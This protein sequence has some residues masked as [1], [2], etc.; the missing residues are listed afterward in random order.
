MSDDLLGAIAS[1]A[2]DLLS[3]LERAV[4]VPRGMRDLLTRLGAAPTNES[5]GLLTAIRAVLVA[6]TEIQNLAAKDSPSLDDIVG[7]LTAMKSAFA[8]LRALDASGGPLAQLPG[9]GADLVELLVSSWLTARHPVLHQ[10]ATLLT[11]IQLEVD[12]GYAEPIVSGSDVVRYPYRI[13]R[14]RLDRLA[15]LLRDPVGVL[16]DAYVTPLTTGA[17]ADAMADALFPKVVGLLRELGVTCR[18]GVN[19]GDETMLGDSA[20]LVNHALVI[21]LVDPLSDLASEA[22]VVVSISSADRGDLGLVVSPFGTLTTTRFLG[23]FKIDLALTA[24]VDAIAFGRHGLT[25]LAS[26]ATTDVT[27]SIVADLPHDDEPAF[28]IGSPT[29][30]RIEVGGARLAAEAT[31]TGPKKRLAVSADVI[32]SALVIPRND[33]DGFIADILPP[34]GIRVPFDLGIGWASDTGVTLRGS[35]GLEANVAVGLS[36]GPLNLSSLHLALKAQ[37]NGGIDAEV[38]ANLTVAIGPLRASVERLGL[39]AALSFP[40]NGGNLGVADLSL[41]L[42]PPSGVGLAVEAQGVLTGGGFLFFDPARGLYAGV[43]QLSLQDRI[44]L[45]A[46]G[47]ITTKMPDGRPG[48]SILIFIT[49][50]GFQPIPLGLGFVLESIGGMVGIHRT[51]DQTVL[52]AGL[53]NDT[54]ASLLFPRDPVGNAPALLQALGAAFPAQRGHYLLGLLARIT[55]FTPTLVQADLALILEFGARTR[56]L[57]LARVSALL[58]T[59]D[60]DLVRLTMDAIGVLDFDAGTLEADAVLVDSRLVHRF[61]ITGGAALRARWKNGSEFVLAVGGF[62]PRFAVPS[63]FPAIERVTLALTAGKNPRLVCESYFA[64]TANTVQF[65]ARASLYAEAGGFSLTGD[66]GFDALLTL[67]PPHFLVEFHATVQLKRGSHNLFKLSLDGRLEGPLPLRLSGKVTFEILWVS[68][69][70]RVDA[71][72]ADGSVAAGGLP[73]VVLEDLVRAALANAANWRAELTPGVSHGVSLRAPSDASGGGPVLD[74][75][76]RL[77]VAQQEAPLN[78]NRDV[79]VVGGAPVAGRRRFSL[80]GQLDGNAAE[81]AAVSG[82]FAPARYFAMSDD[83]KLAAPSFETMDAGL[84]LGDATVR[85]GSAP[86]SVVPAPLEYEPI[87]LNPVGAPPVP[88]DGASAR[89]QLPVAALQQQVT[90]GA[91]AR[92]PARRVGQSRFRTPVSAPAATV[93]RPRWALVRASDGLVAPSAPQPALAARGLASVAPPPALAAL[94]A[95]DTPGGPTWSEQQAALARLNRGGAEWLMV[96]EHE[97][98]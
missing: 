30:T 59:R 97:L 52:T 4:E 69:T 53:K 8:A 17:E 94:A 93:G 19:D 72:L 87:T 44:T 31:L 64:L 73:A 82:S 98:V 63:G 76:G 90:S 14:F 85:Y 40:S 51:F 80:S 54:L 75:L 25:L 41:G 13:E 86:S 56:L 67:M 16:R 21:Y 84:V 95:S 36:L 83:A 5:D 91:A 89:Y 32:S 65:G 29:G 96:P 78:L 61:P 70:V 20:A 18:Y 57:M 23:P 34:D 37:A 66:V 15:S 6:K 35:A 7:V 39:S 28:V 74:P 2:S 38:S 3:P 46:F 43:L 55:W 24:G 22:G 58:P 9:F 60:N 33:N 48:Y 11:L 49:A 12:Q 1:A 62:H 68:F 50:D 79:E 47:L 71:T 42:K 10:V 26:T 77:I 81:V 45:T 92:A 88:D 27:G